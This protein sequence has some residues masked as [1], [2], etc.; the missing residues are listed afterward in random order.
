MA[1]IHILVNSGSGKCT[2]AQVMAAKLVFM[3]LDLDTIAGS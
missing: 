1:C 3:Y 2:L